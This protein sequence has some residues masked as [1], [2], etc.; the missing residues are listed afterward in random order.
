MQSD[1][2]KAE[3]LSLRM[4]QKDSSH[5][6]HDADRVVSSWFRGS[7][8]T[9]QENG[10]GVTIQTDCSFPS[11]KCAPTS[12]A[13]AYASHKKK[14]SLRIST[15]QIARN[16]VQSADHESEIALSGLSSKIIQRKARWYSSPNNPPPIQTQHKD[17]PFGSILLLSAI[18]PKTVQNIIS[19]AIQ[20]AW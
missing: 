8:I 20:K 2:G 11:I 15:V 4:I 12:N 1:H 7:F 5:I 13:T 14:K 18:W 19:T 16:A 3:W 17:I 9:M 6:I 10:N